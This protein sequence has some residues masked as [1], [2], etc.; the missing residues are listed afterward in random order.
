MLFNF[1]FLITQ[2][3][4]AAPSTGGLF[5]STTTTAPAPSTGGL[6]GSTAAAP[7]PASTGLFGSTPTPARKKYEVLCL[8]LCL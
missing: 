2:K 1:T 6:F 5:G 7:K 3:A 4:P 8:I